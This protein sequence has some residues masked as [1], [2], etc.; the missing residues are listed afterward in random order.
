MFETTCEET[1]LFFRN[2]DYIFYTLRSYEFKLSDTRELFFL[3]NKLLPWVR[4]QAIRTPKGKCENS[5][6]NNLGAIDSVTGEE[7]TSYR[8]CFSPLLKGDH[9]TSDFDGAPYEYTSSRPIRTRYMTYP[10]AGNYKTFK[11]VDDDGKIIWQE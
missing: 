8:E 10:D 9:D 1:P 4:V 6:D 5:V 11:L 3:Q 2:P 7:G